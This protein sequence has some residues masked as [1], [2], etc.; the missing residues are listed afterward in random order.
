MKFLSPLARKFHTLTRF[1]EHPQLAIMRW[2]GVSPALYEELTQ[3]WLMDLRI[4]TVLDIGANTGQFAFAAHAAWPAARI[5]SFEPLPD[6][7]QQLQKRMA[8]AKKF[9]AFNV[10]LGETTGTLSFEKNNFSASSSFLPMAETHKTAFPMTL[11][12]QTIDVRVETL[13]QMAA[14]LELTQPC[15]IKIDVQGYEDRVLRGGERT[16]KLARVIVIETSFEPLYENQST[17]NDIYSML[18]SWNF[19][20]AGAVEHLHHPLDGRILQ[21][22]SIFIREQARA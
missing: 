4:G 2:H 21:A 19:R 9:S 8:R 11:R 1:I 13:D 18:R 7:F 3:K 20:Y 17:F 12:T 14:Q 15:L 10:A 5:Y 22:D 16:V 6:C